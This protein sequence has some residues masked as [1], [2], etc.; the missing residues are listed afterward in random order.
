MKALLS[1]YKS[2]SRNHLDNGNALYKK[3]E[4]ENFQNKLE[5]IQ[6]R[7]YLAITGAIQGRS[8]Q[9]LYNELGLHSLSKRRWRNKLIFLIKCLMDFCQNTSIRT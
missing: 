3:P 1:I 2:F 9:K 7:A 6:Y 5:E 4:S 8:K